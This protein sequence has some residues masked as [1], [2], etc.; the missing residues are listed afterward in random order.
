VAVVGAGELSCRRLPSNSR[1]RAA[2]VPFSFSSWAPRALNV[3]ELCE[4][5]S[6]VDS[7]WRI[8]RSLARSFSCA[9]ASAA[10]VFWAAIAS[11]LKSSEHLARL[12]SSATARVA[13][14]FSYEESQV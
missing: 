2:R 4:M 6:S 11:F 13:S 9:P 1:T 7:R 8:S 14:W 5:D 10:A 12:D 3:S